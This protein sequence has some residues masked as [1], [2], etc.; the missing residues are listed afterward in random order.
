MTPSLRSIPGGLSNVVLA[1]PANIQARRIGAIG[2]AA[3]RWC[4]PLCAAA[5]VG[6]GLWVFFRK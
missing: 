3:D 6:V 5:F 2:D 4:M 1:A